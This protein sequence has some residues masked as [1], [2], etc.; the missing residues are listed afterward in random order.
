MDSRLALCVVSTFHRPISL[1]PLSGPCS[2]IPSWWRRL[3]RTC[4]SISPL[5]PR[6]T[7]P[8][9][10]TSSSVFVEKE[11]EGLDQTKGCVFVFPSVKT[12]HAHCR[13]PPSPNGGRGSAKN[14]GLVRECCSEIH[15]KDDDNERETVSKWMEEKA[16]EFPSLTHTK[17]IKGPKI[18]QSLSFRMQKRISH[19]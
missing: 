17:C 10:N 13:K 2:L 15:W 4:F 18:K 3:V 16:R 6:Q 14:S 1:S 11:A 5:T 12:L 7:S 19:E 9:Q 8:S